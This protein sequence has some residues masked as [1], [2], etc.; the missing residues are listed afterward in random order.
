MV[1][2]KLLKDTQIA[3]IVALHKQGVLTGDIAN[4]V[5]VSTR[6]VQRWIKRFKEGGGEEIPE[7][8]QSTGRPR[9]LT[10]RNENYV[11]LLVE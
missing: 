3:Q 10:T 5:G 7:H 9:K 4:S 6:S 8:S 1:C 11:K 2:D